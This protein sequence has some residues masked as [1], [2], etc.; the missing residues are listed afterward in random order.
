MEMITW[1]NE[2]LLK[3]FGDHFGDFVEQSDVGEIVANERNS[4]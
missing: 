1:L 2:T 3:G 4:G